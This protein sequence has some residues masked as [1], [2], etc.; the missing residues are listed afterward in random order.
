MKCPICGWPLRDHH[1]KFVYDHGTGYPRLVKKPGIIFSC[2]W[3][4]CL[5]TRSV[6]IFNVS[7]DAFVD[8][9]PIKQSE[10]PNRLRGQVAMD[11]R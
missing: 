11:Y 10:V 3:C 7:Y 8:R 9:G 6:R 4:R 5:Y 2:R 1:R